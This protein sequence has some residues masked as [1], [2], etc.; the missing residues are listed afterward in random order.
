M[1]AEADHLVAALVL[2]LAVMVALAVAV[3]RCGRP[4]I[5][6]LRGLNRTHRR[7]RTLFRDRY[8]R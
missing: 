4:L 8:R 3:A 6:R 2:V 1:V 5:G 7:L